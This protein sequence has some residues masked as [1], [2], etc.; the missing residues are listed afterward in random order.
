MDRAKRS[1][2]IKKLEE[3]RGSRVITYITG[4]RN[5]TAAQIFDDALR[6]IY[7]Q[8]RSFADPK[9]LDVFVYSRG[10]AIDVPW[11]IATALRQTSKEWNIL[12][13]FRAHSAA[14]LLALGA[15]EIVL[16]KNGEMGPIDPIM[17]LQRIVPVPGGGTNIVPDPVPVEDIMAYLRLAVERGGLSDQ[18]ALSASFAKLTDRI[19]PPSLGNAYRTYSHIRDVARRMLLSRKNPAPQAAMESIIETLAEKVY[20]HGH[21]IGFSDA[22]T[23]GLP[24]VQANPELDKAMWELLNLYEVDMKLLEPLDPYKVTANSD[25]YSE[26]ATIAMVES[27]DFAYEHGG[28]VQVRL[29]RQMPPALNVNF[30]LSLQMPQ[31]ATGAQMPQQVQ[32]ALQQMLQQA[33]QGLMQQAQ[34]A[35][36]QAMQQQAP[37]I[38]ADVRFTG[39]TWTKVV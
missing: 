26:Q 36:Q 30:T 22:K 4:D 16:G 38:N 1:A 19:D 15:D 5:P 21:A 28:E 13:P 34:Q 20:A 23:I 17:T 39:G 24:V 18:T 37:V 27:A 6:P 2:A 3:L 32:Q 35:V 7:E 10:G 31:A 33:Q 29:K 8:L 14:T 11:R 9:K 12:I 25:S